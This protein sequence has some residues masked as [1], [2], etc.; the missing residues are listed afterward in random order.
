MEESTIE[1]EGMETGLAPPLV[2]SGKQHSIKKTHALNAFKT[3]N[4]IRK[5]TVEGATSLVNQGSAETLNQLRRITFQNASNSSE[6]ISSLSSLSSGER[7][8]ELQSHLD[9]FKFITTSSSKEIMREGH[10][11]PVSCVAVYTPVS[12]NGRAEGPELITGS[13]EKAAPDKKGSNLI[14]WDMF[15][16]EKIGDL[17]G[18]TGDVTAMAVLASRSILF[19]GTN[20]FL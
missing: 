16:R 20:S 9:T 1:G 19:V 15:S 18:V 2:E 10:N 17:V 4:Q 13:S 3:L 7:D 8:E 12:S 14:I 6:K 5:G 11:N